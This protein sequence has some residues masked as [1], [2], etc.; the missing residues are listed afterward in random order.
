[1]NGLKIKKTAKKRFYAFLN[2]IYNEIILFIFFTMKNY[3]KINSHYFL[4]SL[5]LSIFDFDQLLFNRAHV[6][7]A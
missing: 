2:H 5:K 3:Q 4:F 7:R 6:K 1:M